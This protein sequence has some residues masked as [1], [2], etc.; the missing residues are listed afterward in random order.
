MQKPIKT[1]TV[2]YSENENIAGEKNIFSSTMPRIEKIGN[3]A[4]SQLSSSLANFCQSVGQVLNGATTA[5]SDYELDT[6][7]ITA[8]I[9]GKG[10]I[11]LVGS[12]STEVKGGIKLIFKRKI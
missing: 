11:R 2:I 8:E 6:F 4:Q 5:I 7:E 12:V 9:S 1:L 10:E 3:I